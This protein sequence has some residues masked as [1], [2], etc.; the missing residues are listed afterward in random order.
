MG[1]LGWAERFF[2]GWGTSWIE[3]VMTPNGACYVSRHFRGRAR[4]PRHAPPRTRPYPPETNGKTERFI[5]TLLGVWASSRPY[6]SSARRT[7]A[8][9][10]WLRYC[11]ERQPRR[12]LGMTPPLHALLALTQNNLCGPTARERP[13]AGSAGPTSGSRLS[14]CGSS[15]GPHRGCRA[16]NRPSPAKAARPVATDASPH[17]WRQSTSPATWCSGSGCSSAYARPRCAAA[18]APAYPPT[19]AGGHHVLDGTLLC[20]RE[21]PHLGAH[22]PSKL[23]H[24]YGVHPVRLG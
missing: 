24:H 3:R 14:A 21:R 6:R 16:T 5:Q 17:R 15:P 4:A 22:R 9:R 13:D 7:R 8:L 20:V 18:L 23:S 2:L 1:F 11:N 10:L 12:S 19:A